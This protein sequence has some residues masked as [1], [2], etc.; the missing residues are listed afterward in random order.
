MFL[1]LSVGDLPHD[2]PASWSVKAELFISFFFLFSAGAHQSMTKTRCQKSLLLYF[3]YRYILVIF[4]IPLIPLSC[5]LKQLIRSG[6]TVMINLVPFS[7]HSN[8]VF[9]L[10]V[11]HPAPI[12]NS[13]ISLKYYSNNAL[14][15]MTPR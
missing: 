11:T 4:S 14:T 5:V 1:R 7:N 13:F 12:Q 8:S 3:L 9:S 15:L 2:L 10:L 6:V